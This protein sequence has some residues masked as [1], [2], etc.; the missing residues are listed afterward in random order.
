M[1][2]IKYIIEKILNR[3]SDPFL[4]L[5]ILAGFITSFVVSMANKI[6]ANFL[7]FSPIF[8]KIFDIF[9]FLSFFGIIACFA[10]KLLRKLYNK[11]LQVYYEEKKK[12]E[13]VQC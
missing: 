4:L 13:F 2:K 11:A 10:G 1:V 9:M 12:E 6:D 3:L 7:M 8:Y 5:W